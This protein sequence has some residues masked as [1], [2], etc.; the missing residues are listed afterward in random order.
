MKCR[1]NGSFIKK[2]KKQTENWETEEEKRE[3][4]VKENCEQ[5][6]HQVPKFV[7]WETMWISILWFCYGSI[8]S[9]WGHSWQI[10]KAYICFVLYRKF[11][12]PEAEM[13]MRRNGRRP[14]QPQPKVHMFSLTSSR[15]APG[16]GDACADIG[17]FR[18]LTY[19]MVSNQPEACAF[20]MST[21]L[22]NGCTKNRRQCGIN[23][24]LCIRILPDPD[25]NPDPS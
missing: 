8:G 21:F 9:W 7:K 23:S 2:K 22:L 11:H 17:Y 4:I 10:Q 15:L 14:I 18:K 6:N 19:F 25:S 3:K 16:R 20:L 24:V 12:H 5:Q 1:P 13:W